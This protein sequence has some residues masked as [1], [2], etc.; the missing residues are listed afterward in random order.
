MSDQISTLIS[1]TLITY[2]HYLYGAITPCVSTTYPW[3]HSVLLSHHL[4]LPTDHPLGL[5]DVL[6]QQSVIQHP[7][8]MDVYIPLLVYSGWVG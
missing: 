1:N 2:T 4:D 7:P 5:L 8:I 3:Y 6:L